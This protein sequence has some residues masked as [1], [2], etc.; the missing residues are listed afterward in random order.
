LRY[1]QGL[2]LAEIARLTVQPDPFRVNRQV[3]AALDA[4]AELVGSP[5]TPHERKIR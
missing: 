1:E 2:T 5:R 3:Q 4:L